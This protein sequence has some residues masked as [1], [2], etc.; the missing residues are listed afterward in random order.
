[1]FGVQLL[2]AKDPWNIFVRDDSGEVDE[3]LRHIEQ[4]IDDAFKKSQLDTLQ[5]SRKGQVSL[6]QTSG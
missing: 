5:Q 3:Q 2:Q 1:M 6:F 4:Q